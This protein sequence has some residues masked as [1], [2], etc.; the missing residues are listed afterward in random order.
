MSAGTTAADLAIHGGP[1]AFP[2]MAG[3]P[4]A[5][6]GIDEFM[7]V[8]E[9][10]GF[11]PE[12]LGR[13]RAAV[14]DQDLPG[15]GAGPHL[16]RYYGFPK[17]SKGEQFEDLA[18]ETFGV[19]FA[20]G[21]SSGT[22]ALHCAMVAVGAAPGK[23][24]ICPALGFL[25]T[26]MAAALVGAK[27][28]F[29]DVDESLQMD[30]QKLEALITPRTVAVVPTHHW[31]VVCDLGPVV[32]IARRHRISVIE[33]CAQAPGATYRGRHVGS[34]GDIGCFSIS[35]YKIIGGGEGGLICTHDERLFD[36]MRQVA[37]AGGLWRPNRFAPER[38]PGELFPGT[39]Y[40]MSELE[41]AIDIVQ[42]RKLDSIVARHREV[43]RRIKG[44]L[45]EYRE[46][47][48][49]NSNDP[50]GDIGYMLRFFPE[51]HVLGAK[52][53]AALRAEGIGAGF[54]GAGAAPDW[55]VC[56]DMFPLFRE[57][58]AACRAELCPVAADLYDRTV[59]VSLNQWYSPA[60]CDALAAGVRK[61][62]SAYCTP[63]GNGATSPAE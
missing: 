52:I 8:A 43:W 1:K 61:V 13:L 55:H 17:P 34:V 5:K 24:V 49:Q 42:L 44:Q 19:R 27:P 58:G 10:F 14:T 50:D 11:S 33:D 53:A 16:G 51:T 22:A 41:A 23:E 54:R 62:L 45:G 57:H 36:R 35:C 30:P 38:Y 63:A 48:W 4:Q 9:R 25:A 6:I 39:N 29:C 46:V 3:R 21:V 20:Q 60:D 12:A 2:A 28:V 7:A 15:D 59:T 47:R 56:K 32:E 37:E 31:G 40:R 18:R 26:S